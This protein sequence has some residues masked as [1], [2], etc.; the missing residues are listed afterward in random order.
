MGFQV[1]DAAFGF[2]GLVLVDVYD[3]PDCTSRHCQNYE[4]SQMWYYSPHDEMLRHST[5]T[6]SIQ[7]LDDHDTH[8]N[9]MPTWQYHCLA[10]VLGLGETWDSTS[11]KHWPITHAGTIAG[12]SEV[13]GGPL[14]GGD[15]VVALLNRGNESATISVRYSMLEISS[16]G[17][18]SIFRIENLWDGFDLGE[19]M[20]G[21]E[22]VVPSHDIAIFRLRPTTGG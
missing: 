18:A 5:V 1:S 2:G 8:T 3:Q 17:D 20:T 13:W 22:Q 10:H 6:A 4:P 19:H 9:K 21:F 7:R 16:I 15:F 14:E 11:S 12:E